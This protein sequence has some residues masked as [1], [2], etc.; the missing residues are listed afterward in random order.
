MATK[1]YEEHLWTP[2]QHYTLDQKQKRLSD[3]TMD[4]QQCCHNDHDTSHPRRDYQE[5]TRITM[6]KTG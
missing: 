4:W 1:V 5:Y 3:P 6:G 2:I